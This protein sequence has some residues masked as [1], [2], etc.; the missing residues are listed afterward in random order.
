MRKQPETEIR[1]YADNDADY[2]IKSGITIGPYEEDTI[3]KQG[4]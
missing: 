3:E 1:K 4:W 2:C